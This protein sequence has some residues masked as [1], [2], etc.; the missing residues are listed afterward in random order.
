M[1]MNEKAKVIGIAPHF[2]VLDVVET[3]E[4]Y[5]DV[6]GFNILGYFLDPPVYAMVER[7]GFQIHF[8]KSDS[9]KTQRNFEIRTISS[10]FILWIPEIDKFYDEVKSKNAKILQD[11]VTRPYGNREFIIS[12]CNGFRITIAD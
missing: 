1:F 5:R 8:G 2:V 9:D 12:D 11:I 7:D 3:A 10:D 4:Y 6:L